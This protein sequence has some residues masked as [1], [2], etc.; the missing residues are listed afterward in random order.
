MPIRGLILLL[1]ITII[2]AIFYR[3]EIYQWITSELSGDYIEEYDDDNN[4]E[5]EQKE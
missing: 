2:L 4:F 5:E 3:N 1:I